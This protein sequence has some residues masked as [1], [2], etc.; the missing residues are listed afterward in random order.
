MMNAEILAVGTEL[1][2]GQITN[3]NAQYLS[4]KLAEIGVAVYHHTVVGDNFGRAEKTLA[5][6]KDRGANVILL[7]GGLGPTED[8]LTRE[9]VASFIGR[10]LTLSDV[11]VEHL[12]NTFY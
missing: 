9:V 12:L 3:T 7:S 2:M 11:I 6:A 5:I 10:K 8:D 4:K 1:L